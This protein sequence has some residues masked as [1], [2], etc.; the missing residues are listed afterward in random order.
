M[1][2]VVRHGR[3]DLA[4]LR[5]GLEADVNA[6]ADVRCTDDDVSDDVSK[7]VFTP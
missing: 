5:V 3:R 4:T 1:R 6:F 7:V 2:P